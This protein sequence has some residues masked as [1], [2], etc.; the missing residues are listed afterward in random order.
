[1]HAEGVDKP[2]LIRV[3][4]RVDGI[5]LRGGLRL[6]ADA[7]ALHAGVI[8]EGAWQQ[9]RLAAMHYLGRRGEGFARPERGALAGHALAVGEFADEERAAV[10]GG[11]GA[12]V[13][14]LAV[15]Q[16]VVVGLDADGERGVAV[17]GLG[18]VAIARGD[19]HEG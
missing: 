1:M 2:Q 15:E 16:V 9:Q 12:E 14:L 13:A 6:L 7:D 17:N 18:G 3:A 19:G 11:G 5:V 4:G 8:G 10:D